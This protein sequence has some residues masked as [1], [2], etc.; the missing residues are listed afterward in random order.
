MESSGRPLPGGSTLWIQK[1][2]LFVKDPTNRADTAKALN[3]S[4]FKISHLN[5]VRLNGSN[6]MR[7]H[8]GLLYLMLLVVL[9]ALTLTAGCKQQIQST[10]PPPSEPASSLSDDEIPADD[11]IMA[12]VTS[13][14][15]GVLERANLCSRETVFHLDT[16]VE[17]GTVILAGKT[18]DNRLKQAIVDSISQIPGVTIDDQFTV[19]PPP[20]L[21]DKT[22][23]VVKLPVINL[24]EAPGRAEGSSTVTQARM[25]DIVRILDTQDGWYLVQM[26]DKYLGW[27]SPSTIALYDSA[28]LDAFWSG[29]IAL[30][31][32]KMTQALDAPG[33]GMLFAKWLV[34]GS[35]LPVVSVS[36]EWAELSLPG[37]GSTFVKAESI[38]VFP[39]LD[40]VFQEQKTAAD[41]IETA[42]QYLGLPYLWG[43]CTSYG[44]DC[45]GFTQFCFKMNGYQLRRDADLQYEQ[46]TPV[47]SVENLE[48]GDLVFFE[49]YR[50]GPS[51]VGIYIGDH[52]YIHSGSSSGVAINSF[53]PSHPDY[54]AS[55]A[56]KFL[57]GRR[58]IK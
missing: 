3:K 37:G 5:K 34:Q 40:S 29:E 13:I 45:S 2:E 49:T 38:E 54:S 36:D 22:W 42:K 14:I 51:H 8:Y 10:V 35:V 11:E 33:G 47:Q 18:S 27:V 24:G 32:A 20:E 44:F 48:P 21:G 58:I 41:I 6:S 55:L 39:D 16:D 4:R 28:L 43:G 53:E 9:G 31:T 46:G 57:G 25:G 23:G 7:K 19:M 26:H 56:Q 17:G 50:P 12:S 30:I 1:G 52:R 15:E